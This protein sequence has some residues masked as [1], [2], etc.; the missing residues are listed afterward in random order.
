MEKKKVMPCAETLEPVRAALAVLSGKWALPVVIAVKV[1]NVRFTT[2]QAA[3]VGITPKV[4]A[5]ELKL[6]AQH[7]LIRRVVADDY[8]V[9]VTYQLLPH[10]ATLVPIITALKDWGVLHRQ[11]VQRPTTAA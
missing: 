9:T 6:L 8:P 1:G 5:K 3:I 11:Q 2:I 7:Q 4:L 10:A